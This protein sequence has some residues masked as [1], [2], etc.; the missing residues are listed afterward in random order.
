[1]HGKPLSG[2]MYLRNLKVWYPSEIIRNDVG[3]GQ[4]LVSLAVRTLSASGPMTDQST[5]P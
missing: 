1:M 5:A 2:K 3:E 4:A